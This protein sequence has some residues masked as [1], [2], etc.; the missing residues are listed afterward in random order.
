MNP[1]N[2]PTFAF[3][4][5]NATYAQVISLATFTLFLL[6]LPDIDPDFFPLPYAPVSD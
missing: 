4:V 1:L 5:K 6:C 2:N 3:Y